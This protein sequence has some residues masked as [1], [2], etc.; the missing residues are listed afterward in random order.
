MEI[1]LNRLAN[2]K[3]KQR[4]FK[5]KSCLQDIKLNV[6]FSAATD[7]CIY[8]NLNPTRTGLFCRSV[9]LGGASRPPCLKIHNSYPI[10]TKLGTMVEW[11]KGN[12]MTS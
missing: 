9:G 12:I 10:V 6:Y 1:K 8:S 2:M 7:L 3:T 5:G 11:P 4:K